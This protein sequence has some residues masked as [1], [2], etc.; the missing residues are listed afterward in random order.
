MQI[1]YYG[2]ALTV[3]APPL[4]SACL[5]VFM[6]ATHADMICGTP[7]RTGE[8]IL[9]RTFSER[10]DNEWRRLVV[11]HTV[12]PARN[13]LGGKLFTPSSLIGSWKGITLVRT[14]TPH[15][16]LGSTDLGSSEPNDPQVPHIIEF[17]AILHS[18]GGQNQNPLNI[19]MNYFESEMELH[20]HHCLGD[21]IPIMPGQTSDGI[22]D[23]PVNA[24]I[25]L[26]TTFEER[27]VSVF[28]SGGYDD[29]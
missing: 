15:L 26:G 10:M 22:G 24:W 2:H 16:R 6:L 25:P 19:T 3:A 17:E 1:Q 7:D 14:S 8:Y 20:E 18:D 4:A 13:P 28:V 12:T 9:G 29:G 5:S 21:E 11:C 27:N 23:N